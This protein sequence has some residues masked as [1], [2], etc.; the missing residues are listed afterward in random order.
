MFP[1]FCASSFS[2]LVRQSTP[3]HVTKPREDQISRGGLLLQLGMLQSQA[4]V[5]RALQRRHTIKSS[6][7][8]SILDPNKAGTL[9]SNA[10]PSLEPH[11]L[12]GGGAR[13]SPALRR[14]VFAALLCGGLRSAI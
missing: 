14:R 7:L 4:A 5:R 6:G 9:A 3:K 11:A 13:H 1:A 2:R 8:L 10:A 12:G